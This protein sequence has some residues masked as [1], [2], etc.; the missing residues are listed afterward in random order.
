MAEDKKEEK[1]PRK[2]NFDF[3]KY[4]SKMDNIYGD[5]RKLS[6][7]TEHYTPSRRYFNL[8]T[9][10][11][12]E[13][14]L[15]RAYSDPAEASDVSETLFSLD[16]NYAKVISY[17]ANMFY[18]RYTVLPVQLDKTKNIS[19]EEYNKK[20]AE[21]VQVADGV[22]IESLVPE[23]LH[24][25]FIKGSVYFYGNKHNKTKT[26]SVLLLPHHYCR[27]IYTTS[28]GTNAIEFD[29][30][31]FD[32]FRGDEKEEVFEIFPNEFKK[33][34]NEAKKQSGQDL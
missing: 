23:L 18:M 16:A 26:T 24:E 15:Q 28:Q 5:E 2:K 22:N 32:Q 17:F 1:T 27:T 34:Y 25:L 4:D 21:M 13:Q 10:D 6:R 20:Y 9:K 19:S 11:D 29:M 8:D 30:A 33:K 12:V 3:T 14:L 31:Y 7:K